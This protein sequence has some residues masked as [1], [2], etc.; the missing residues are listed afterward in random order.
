ML[1][2]AARS[3]RRRAITRSCGRSGTAP[4]GT[5]LA[6]LDTVVAA[7]DGNREK[8]ST[9]VVDRLTMSRSDPLRARR[10]GA[11]TQPG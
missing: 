4:S 7:I 9:S 5:V 6:L 1:T 3:S 2:A 8:I 11:G 10:V